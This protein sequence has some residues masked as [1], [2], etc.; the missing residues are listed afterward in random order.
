MRWRVCMCRGPSGERGEASLLGQL[1][2]RIEP[3]ETSP[4]HRGLGL[5]LARTRQDSRRLGVRVHKAL[6]VSFDVCSQDDFGW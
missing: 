4:R 3:Q 6:T 2:G 1:R 5:V